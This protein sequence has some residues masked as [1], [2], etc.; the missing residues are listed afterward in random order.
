MVDI[1]NGKLDALRS[2]GK[3]WF[4]PHWYVGLALCFWQCGIVGATIS[5]IPFII[6]FLVDD[7]SP[8]RAKLM[9]QPSPYKGEIC[10]V[11][12]DRFCPEMCCGGRPTNDHE[13]DYGVI[14]GFV[15][16]WL[17]S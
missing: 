3:Y 8:I 9:G 11:C 7:E 4:F 16:L 10:A 17:Q 13:G 15:G 6:A 14:P 5:F 1:C 2:L 12:Q